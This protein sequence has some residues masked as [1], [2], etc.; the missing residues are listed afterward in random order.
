MLGED[1]AP[2]LRVLRRA[3]HDLRA[4]RLDHRPAVRLLLVRDPNH[5]D[6][7][8]EADQLARERERA[9]PLPRARLGRQPGA[10]LAL[11]VERLRDRR[12]RLV[13]AGRADAFVL[14]EDARPRADRLLEAAR[15]QQG[16]RPPEPVELEDLL[17]DRDLRVLAHLLAD[18]LHRE[19]RREIVRP[20]RLAGA[21]MEHRLRRSRH[22]GA[23]VVP[24]SRKLPFLEEEPGLCPRVR[25]R[26]L[27]AESLLQRGCTNATARPGPPVPSRTLIGRNRTS[28]P[29]G[30]SCARLQSASTKTMPAASPAVCAG[31]PSSAAPI[32]TPSVPTHRTPR[33]SRW[34][35]ASAVGDGQPGPLCETRAS[36]AYGNPSCPGR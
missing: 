1:R 13:A 35:I 32:E 8:V 34:S 9:A 11:V 5:V 4:P 33:A 2:G 31:S 22:V 27:H 7:A 10:S 21:R 14:E 18:Q 12:V 16:R 30:G 29:R 24:A 3:R 17:R 15:A 6:L 19:E 23:D 25:P 20:D 26:L 28:A 36:A